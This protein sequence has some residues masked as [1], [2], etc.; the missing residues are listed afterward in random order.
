MCLLRGATVT[1]VVGSMEDEGLNLYRDGY[2]TVFPSP[3][4]SYFLVFPPE[5]CRHNIV[6]P[7][8]VEEKSV[9]QERRGQGRTY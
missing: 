7:D 8:G 2:Y 1:H 9:K 6:D 3:R 5:D 4:A